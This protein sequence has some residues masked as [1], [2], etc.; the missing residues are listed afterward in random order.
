MVLII[1]IISIIPQLYIPSGRTLQ[2]FSA[3]KELVYIEALGSLQLSLDTLNVKLQSGDCI[4]AQR[5]HLYNFNYTPTSIRSIKFQVEQESLLFDP[6]IVS[7]FHHKEAMLLKGLLSPLFCDHSEIAEMEVLVGDL[8][9]EWAN[10]IFSESKRLFPALYGQI[11]LRMI[12]VNRYL[13]NHHEEVITLQQLADLI[14]CNPVYLSN[15][16]SKIFN[17]SPIKHLQKM[18]MTKAKALLNLTDMSVQKI[19]QQVGYISASQF[20]DLFKK[21]HGVTPIQFRR[22]SRQIYHD[23]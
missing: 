5:L 12:K 9:Q 11:D 7:S 20:S 1:N 16:Y 15:T 14:Q 17:I 6:P 3:N 10:S 21:H 2:W 22:N 8:F 19:S 13:R 18:K 4:L 23:K